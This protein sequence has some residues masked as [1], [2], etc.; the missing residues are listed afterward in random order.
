MNNQNK[1]ML[2]F[3]VEIITFVS[4]GYCLALHKYFMAS[5]FLCIAF[6]SAIWTG[7]K[8]KEEALEKE[9]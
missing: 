1:Q 4:T 3:M 5:I 7:K 8:I 9:K 2:G 6:L